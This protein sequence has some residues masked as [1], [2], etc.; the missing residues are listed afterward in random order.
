[1]NIFRKRLLGSRPRRD[2]SVY[3]AVLGVAMILGVIGLASMQIA[4]IELRAGVAG[5]EMARA[6]LMAQSGVE[7]ALGRLDLDPNWRTTYSHGVEEPSDSWIS[8]GTTG[9]FRFELRDSD[10]DLADDLTDPVTVRGIGKV[11]SATSVATVLIEPTGQ[12][13]TCLEVSLQSDGNLVLASEIT[14]TTNQIVSSNGN[15]DASAAEAS[16]AGNAEAGGNIMGIVSGSITPNISPPRQMPD[17]ATVF[18]YYLA[19]GTIIDINTLPDYKIDKVVLSSAYNPFGATNAQGIYV[20]DCQGNPITIK[21]SR[22]AATLVLLNPGSG[23]VMEKDIHW[24]PAVANF[25]ALLVQG[26]FIMDWHGEHQLREGDLNV[27]L[28]PPGAPYRGETDS[29]TNDNYPGVI[30]GLTY[31][32]GNLL[33]TRQSTL[34]GVVVVGG[35]VA[36]AADVDLTYRSTFFDNP[37]PGFGAGSVMRIVPGTWKRDAY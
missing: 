8:L 28:N 24:E 30:Q 6:R 19:N 23:S 14:L 3:V 9:M 13:L 36:I 10:G 22:L 1:M 32:S 16:I 2:G 15:I 11:G 29:D 25:P 33:I 27:N 5:D 20:I 26:D 17:N 12:G 18:E 34:D 4:R 7:F 37:P 31:I 35:D 21:D